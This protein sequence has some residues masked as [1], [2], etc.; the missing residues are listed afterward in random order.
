MGHLTY[1]LFNIYFFIPSETYYSHLMYHQ[2]PQNTHVRKYT[3]EGKKIVF[4]FEVYFPKARKVCLFQKY[5]SKVT[6]ASG[7]NLPLKGFA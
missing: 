6:S 7:K 4:L 3:I 1:K 2:R 5:T